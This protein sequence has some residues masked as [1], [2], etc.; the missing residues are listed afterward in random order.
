[1]SGISLPDEAHLS[2]YCRPTAVGLDGLP[3]AAAFQLKAGEDYLSVNWLEYFRTPDLETAVVRVREVFRTKGY[4]ISPNGRFAVLGVGTAKEAVSAV[5]GR[6]ARIDHLPL[7]DDASHS[8]IFGYR[9]DDLAVAAELKTLVRHEDVY[10][11]T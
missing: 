1:M 6:P 3:L 2:R 7:D 9:V 4:R 5:V 8:G 10:T 11:A